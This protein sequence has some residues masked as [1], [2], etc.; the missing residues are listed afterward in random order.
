MKKITLFISICLI[1][2]SSTAQ[3]T[4]L[5]KWLKDNPEFAAPSFSNKN[6]EAGGTVKGVIYL[7]K[8]PIAQSAITKTVVGDVPDPNY[9]TPI[10]GYVSIDGKIKA[11]SAA[12]ISGPSYSL[13]WKTMLNTGAVVPHTQDDIV[14]FDYSEVKMFTCYRTNVLD[15]N[16]NPTKYFKYEIAFP[17]GL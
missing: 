13:A 9:G 10:S 5:Q 17:G 12:T 7:T 15:A 3:I 6:V 8:S 16:G 1:T 14:T 11:V 2:L 4:D